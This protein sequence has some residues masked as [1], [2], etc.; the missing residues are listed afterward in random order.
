V[1]PRAGLDRCGKSR[2][3]G[4]RSPDLPARRE[5]LYRLSYPGSKPRQYSL[6]YTLALWYSLLLLGYK[7]VQHVTVLNV[8]LFIFLALQP[9]VVVFSTAR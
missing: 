9:I 4:I 8:C 2:P 3:T 1:G 5:S 7:T 6:I